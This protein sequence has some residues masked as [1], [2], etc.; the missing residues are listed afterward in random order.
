L[1]VSVFDCPSLPNSAT[2]RYWR[3]FLFSE[4][5]AHRITRIQKA[6]R[7]RQNCGAADVGFAVSHFELS[8]PDFSVSLWRNAAE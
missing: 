8:R 5:I 6:M 4:F 7:G 1:C 3:H 2:I